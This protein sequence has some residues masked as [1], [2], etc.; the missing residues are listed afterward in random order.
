[1]SSTELELGP[2]DVVVIGYPSDA[3]R[4]GEAIP[5]LLDLVDRGIVR[6]LDV[7]GVE[8]TA[9]GAINA[10]AI[11]DVDGD[12]FPDLIAFEGAQ[13]GML[14]DEDFQAAAEAMDPGSAAVL[15]VFENSWAA[16]FVSAVRRNGG[17]V[18]GFQRI[19]AEDL[20]E[21]IESLGD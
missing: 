19:P 13:T 4:T 21:A 12:G 11:T 3:P 20:M 18:L 5:L 17:T 15:I 14:G 2:V 1:M 10:L 16:P 6:I 7:A 9:D 8:K